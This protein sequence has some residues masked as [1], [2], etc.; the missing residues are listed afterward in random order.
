VRPK[1]A[2]RIKPEQA[3]FPAAIE[4]RQRL[5][6]GN[7]EIAVGTKATYVRPLRRVELPDE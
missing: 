1:D 3:V 6:T 7:T 2:V 5:G 4:L